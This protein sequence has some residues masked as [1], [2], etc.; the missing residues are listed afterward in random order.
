MQEVRRAGIVSYRLGGADGVSI[1]A[2]KWAWALERLGF[3]VHRIAGAGNGD[4]VEVISGLG[5]EHDGPVDEAALHRALAN[6]DVVIVENL[7]SLPLNP[8]AGIAVASA[9]RH[10]PAILRHHD[11]AWH[12]EDTAALGP[13]PD[14][15]AW[16]HVAISHLGASELAEH[17]VSASVLY[18]RFAMDPPLGNRAKTRAQMGIAATERVVLQPTRALRRKNIPLGL[19]LAESLG[20]TYWLTAAAEDGFGAELESIVNDATTKVLRGQGPG[21]MD[22]VYAAADV[23]VLPSTWEGFGNP[24][25]ESVTH[26][27]PLALARYPVA[28]ELFDLGF[29]FFD[30]HSPDDLHKW[31]IAPDLGLLGRNHA[32]ARQHFD[33]EELPGEIARLL[34]EMGVISADEGV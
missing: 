13:P 26:H 28:N 16:R 17:G 31:L 24:V 23:V 9:L 19:H 5:I 7:L 34:R 25:I 4:T 27:R 20:A 33:I 3:E 22:D 6:L 12:R 32:I 29:A 11:L 10:R 1:E 18:N 30:P 14:D 15:D 8:A 2:E 21:T